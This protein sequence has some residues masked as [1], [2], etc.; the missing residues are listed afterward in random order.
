MDKI[1]QNQVTEFY[2]GF[3][4]KQIHT[5]LNLRHYKSF[6]LI[7]KY[8][9]RKNHHVLEVGCGIGAFTI[10]L[11]RYL[12]TG[13]LLA[14]DI[15]PASIETAKS[16]LSGRKNTSFML[17][18]MSGF[19]TDKTFDF[20]VMLDV[21]EHIPIENHHSLFGC[22][23]KHLAENGTIYINIPHHLYLDYIRTH[24]PEKLQII[25][26]SLGTDLLVDAMY[27]N[28]LR[29]SDIRSYSIFTRENDYQL[30]VLK[31]NKPLEKTIAFSKTG[32]IL[33]K[34]KYRIRSVLQ[35]F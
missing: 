5:G 9:L 8:G 21:L 25:D 29:I 17:T 22:L 10:L 30:I 19:E 18:D 1:T 4:E 13:S 16:F 15:S 27:K 23:R 6:H 32:I 34:L 35:V 28:D 2:N 31:T 11:S 3:A 12:K 33:E 14:T 20:I 26:Q 7:K 24:Q